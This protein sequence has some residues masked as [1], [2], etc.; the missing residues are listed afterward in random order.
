R[1]ALRFAPL[2]TYPRRCGVQ[3][4]TAD[5]LGR[6]DGGTLAVSFEFAG[7]SDP[8]VP[9]PAA[10]YVLLGR[11][12]KQLCGLGIAPSQRGVASL[13]VEV[14]FQGDAGFFGVKLQRDFRP[15]IVAKYR[16]VTGLD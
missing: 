13:V 12:E 10:P 15:G 9:L 3:S 5:R 1:R 6:V 16:P 14:L 4:L 2:F 11:F 8:G 7:G